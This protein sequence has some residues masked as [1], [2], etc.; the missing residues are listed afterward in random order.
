M[1]NNGEYLP[2]IELL[3]ALGAVLYTLEFSYLHGITSLT[4]DQQPVYGAE[5]EM[6][7]G[8]MVQHF[9][10]YRATMT[11]AFTDRYLSDRTE[12]ADTNEHLT[13]EYLGTFCDTM[14]GWTDAGKLI[15]LYPY[16]DS[17]QSLYCIIPG[18]GFTWSPVV[19]GVP[20]TKA[21]DYSLTLIGKSLTT[22]KWVTE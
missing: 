19:D 15:R 17:S 12:T 11:I 21:T 9:R 22:T 4:L 5:V 2:K 10:G 6:A 20:K 14:R 1:I 3:S 7:D 18:G 13:K 8:T 16:S